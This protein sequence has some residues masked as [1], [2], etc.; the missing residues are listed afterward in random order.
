MSGQRI[1]NLK[2]FYLCY[3]MLG[4]YVAARELLNTYYYGQKYY[5]NVYQLTNK[6]EEKL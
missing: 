5:E 1:K 3:N 6:Q 4:E 2:A